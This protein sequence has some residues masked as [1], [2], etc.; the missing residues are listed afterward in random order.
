MHATGWGSELR[1]YSPTWLWLLEISEVS[2]LSGYIGETANV[3]DKQVV[4][5][6]VDDARLERFS[7]GA[8]T[9]SAHGCEMHSIELP[10]TEAMAAAPGDNV[11][12]PEAMG[13]KLLAVM[14]V[15]VDRG[16]PPCAS[17]VARTARVGQP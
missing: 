15:T 16:E 7:P 2:V 6:L 8:A 12:G 4:S 17:P 1:G 11:T 13:P 3:D 9:W 10:S 5:A 14:S